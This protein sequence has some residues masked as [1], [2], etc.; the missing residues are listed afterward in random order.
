MGLGTACE[1]KTSRLKSALIQS[2]GGKKL[3]WGWGK[4]CTNRKI[5]IYI[6]IHTHTHTQAGA[7]A[8]THKGYLENNFQW[9]VN[10]TNTE[11]KIIIYQEYILN[12]LLN[13]V[14]PWTASLVI[15]GNEFLYACVLSADCELRMFWHLPSNTHYR[16]SNYQDCKG[17]HTAPRWND[18]A[19]FPWEQLYADSIIMTT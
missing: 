6:Y 16:W 9:A 7:W 17:D 1:D 3:F 13:L 19:V 14:T 10:K 8:H 15:Q 2:S 5:H 11:E 4:L 18:P 12:L